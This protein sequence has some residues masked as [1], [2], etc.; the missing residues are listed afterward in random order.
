MKSSSRTRRIG[1]PFSTHLGNKPVPWHLGV[2]NLFGCLKVFGFGNKAL[3]FSQKYFLNF[4]FNFFKKY[5]YNHP[6][7]LRILFWDFPA[8][9]PW[10]L[11]NKNRYKEFKNGRIECARFQFWVD[12]FFIF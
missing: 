8:S 4:H 6:G 2:S 10:R 9:K 3:L 7:L 5:H 12:S 1:D 11:L